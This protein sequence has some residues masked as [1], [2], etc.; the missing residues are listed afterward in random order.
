MQ[1]RKEMKQ[2]LAF[3]LRD[4]AKAR[5]LD[6]NQHNNRIL[7]VAGKRSVRAQTDFYKWLKSSEAKAQVKTSPV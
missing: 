7:T 3:Q 5:L 6:S 4:N 2:F 1:I